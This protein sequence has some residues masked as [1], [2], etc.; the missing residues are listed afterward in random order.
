MN[1]IKTI[2]MIITT[3]FLTSIVVADNGVWHRAED[4][5]PGIFG[6]DE[7]DTTTKYQFNN[8]I[9]FFSNSYFNNGLSSSGIT[10]GKDASSI[11]YAYNYESIGVTNP[12]FNL[13]LESPNSV[14]FHTGMTGVEADDN[15]KA[16]MM[17]NNLGN[18]GIGTMNPSEK[19]D[20]NGNIKGNTLF[21]NEIKSNSGGDVIINLG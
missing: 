2:L 1:K 16:R 9:N 20:V 5:K 4:V 11:D 13:R 14:I 12:G 7:N 8:P 17:I 18:V 15:T 21:I 10:I 19:L 3:I 6:S